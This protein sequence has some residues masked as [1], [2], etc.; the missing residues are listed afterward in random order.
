MAKVSSSLVINRS[1]EEVYNKAKDIEKLATFLPNIKEVKVLNQEGSVVDSFWKGEFQGREIKWKERDLW[2]EEKKECHF[3]LIEG[4]FKQYEGIWRFKEEG[5]DKTRVELE[6]EYD[7]GIPLVGALISKFLKKVME[8]NAQAML[9][10]LQE[11][12]EG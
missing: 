4:D 10:A 1:V 11:V 7:L 12:V 5:E 9:K 8:E 6:I 3:S 2:D